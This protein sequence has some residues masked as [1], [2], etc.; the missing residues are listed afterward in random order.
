[1]GRAVARPLPEALLITPDFPPAPGGAQR[2]LHRLA[3]DATRVRFRVVTSAPAGPQDDDRE[4]FAIRRVRT[5]RART[6]AVLA[7]N[8]AGV[9]EGLRRRPDVIVSGHIVT[10][11]AAASLAAVL[12]RPIVQYVYAIELA[13]RP[14]LARF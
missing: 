11:P 3:A 4:T 7:L 6:A 9:M 1:M 2:L 12:R 10:S 14:R 8:A 13:A 5:P